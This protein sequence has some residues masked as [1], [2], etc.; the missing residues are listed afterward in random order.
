MLKQSVIKEFS[1]GELNE[2][3]SV[4]SAS[5]SKMQM[6]HAISPL[7]NPLIIR[8]TRRNV[9]RLATEINKRKNK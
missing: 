5:L 7:E 2:R 6:N 1:D 9:A 8:T 4:E 3:F